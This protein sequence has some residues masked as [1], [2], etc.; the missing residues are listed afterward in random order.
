MVATTAWLDVTLPIHPDMVT[1]PGDPPVRLSRL[2]DLAAGD[3]LNLTAITTSLHCGTHIDAPSHYLPGAAGIE[4][5]PPEAMI[6]PAKLFDLEMAETIKREDLAGL[7]I[8]PGDRVLLR[9]GNSRR[10]AQGRFDPAF[11]GLGEGAAGYLAERRIRTLGVDY[12]SVA[13]M[14]ADQAAVHRR[15]LEAGI[16]LIEGLDLRAVEPGLYQLNCLPLRI[17][18]AEAAPARALLRPFAPCET[19]GGVTVNGNG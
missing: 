12:L 19:T 15:L 9:T 13:G 4:A 8:V 14:Q 1:W 7:G 2:A 18:D 10:Y 16:W 3:G 6:G 11:V 17:R 5:M